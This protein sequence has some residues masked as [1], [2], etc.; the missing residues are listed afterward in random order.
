MNMKTPEEFVKEY[1]QL[2]HSKIE[3]VRIKSLIKCIER[4]KEYHDSEVIK[5]NK[6]CVS[7]NEVAV[8]PDPQHHAME[9]GLNIK[10]PT[11]GGETT[12][13]EPDKCMTIDCPNCIF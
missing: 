8:C 9:L 7:N 2:P 5:L 4:Y 11:C 1:Y 6:P 13:L 12:F 3:T 10:C